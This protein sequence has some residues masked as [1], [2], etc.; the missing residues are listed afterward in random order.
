[1]QRAIVNC[2]AMLHAG[3]GQKFY[4]RLCRL[5]GIK[6]KDGQRNHGRYGLSVKGAKGELMLCVQSHFHQMYQF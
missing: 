3:K 5:Y 1:M 4:N 6:A 2:Y